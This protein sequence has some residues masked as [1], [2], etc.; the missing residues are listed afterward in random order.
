MQN[1]I[2][3]TALSISNNQLHVSAVYIAIIIFLLHCII[4]FFP[5]YGSLFSLMMAIYSRNI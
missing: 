5:T 4:V 3:N 2:P 1:H